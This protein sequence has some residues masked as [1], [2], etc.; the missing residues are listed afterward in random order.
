MLNSIN[1]KNNIYSEE[2]KRK[3]GGG[4]TFKN[5]KDRQ[6]VKISLDVYNLIKNDT[7]F[8]DL[9]YKY[10]KYDILEKLKNHML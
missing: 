3:E 6:T 8:I 7:E 4:K 10:Y 5:I 1:I 9:I 2:V